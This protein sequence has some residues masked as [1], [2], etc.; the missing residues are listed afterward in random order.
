MPWERNLR[1]SLALL[2]LA[3]VCAVTAGASPGAAREHGEFSYRW[4]VKP[5]DKAHPIRSTFGE[6][7]TTFAGPPLPST[8][9]YGG[10]SFSYHNGIDIAVPDGTPVYSVESG[11]V[12]IPSP[13]TVAVDSGGGVMFQYW[14]IIPTV[15][16]GQ[17]VTAYQ[18]VLGHVRPRYGHVH[19]AQ[20]RDGAPVNPLLPGRLGPYADRTRP[21][22]GAV[23]FRTPAGKDELP[24][25]LRG[26][27]VIAAQAWDTSALPVAGNWHGFP[28]APALV[29]W[30]IERARDHSVVLGTQFAFD[31]S[32]S[33]PHVSFWS[34]YARGTTQNM[35]TFKKHR[36][37]REPGRFLYR[38]APESFDTR[39]LPDGIYDVVVTAVDSRGNRGSSQQVFT[40]W[41]KPG[42]PPPT[43]QG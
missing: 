31:A 2:V 32:S 24:E 4:P 34:S 14:H 21:H 22:V 15:A 39:T 3:A 1:S 28:I 16:P 23:T 41:N 11:V 37:W 35:P 17:T 27:V 13:R 12:S 26:H 19:F 42:W 8:L 38:M 18:T 43:P 7:R 33:L 36:Y 20:F 29:S 40:V 9:L 10:G 5:F 6:P 30:R 25:L